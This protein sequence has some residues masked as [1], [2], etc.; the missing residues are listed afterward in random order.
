VTGRVRA[1][2]DFLA[3]H[4]PQNSLKYSIKNTGAGAFF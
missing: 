1:A 2:A 4:E 3:W